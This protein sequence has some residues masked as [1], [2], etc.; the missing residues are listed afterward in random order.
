MLSII[1]SFHS[2]MQAE[3][4]VGDAATE[5]ILVNNGLRQGYTLAPSLFNI[6]FSAVVAYWRARCPEAGVMV[7]Y[8]LGRKLVG[9]RTAKSCLNEIKVTESQFA[10]DATLYSTSRDAFEITTRSSSMQPLIGV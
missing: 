10:G 2:G 9:D 8:K 5:E 7:K 3:V 4:R 1:T 6:Y